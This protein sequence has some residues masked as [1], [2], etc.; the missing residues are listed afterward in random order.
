MFDDAAD[1]RHLTCDLEQRWTVHWS[2]RHVRRPQHRNLLT[3]A[4]HD[5]DDLDCKGQRLQGKHNEFRV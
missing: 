1:E 2:F 5:S 4:E 3:E